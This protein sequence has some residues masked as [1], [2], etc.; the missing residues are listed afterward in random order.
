MTC[1][2]VAEGPV[3]QTKFFLRGKSVFQL[4][5]FS[6]V[7]SLLNGFFSYENVRFSDNNNYNEKQRRNSQK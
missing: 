2:Y 3:M 6:F 4:V 7:V 5:F 1:F